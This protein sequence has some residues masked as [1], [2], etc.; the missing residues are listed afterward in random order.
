MNVDVFMFKSLKLNLKDNLYR[1][2]KLLFEI[3]DQD[4]HKSAVQNHSDLKWN[5]GL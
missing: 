4:E 1:G 3:S 5:G 2:Y